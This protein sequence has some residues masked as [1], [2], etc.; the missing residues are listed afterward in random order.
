MRTYLLRFSLTTFLGAMVFAGCNK[1][2][3]D[4]AESSEIA[5]QVVVP[6]GCGNSL[7]TNLEDLGGLVSGSVQISNDA[8][9]YYIKISET[10]A[11]YDIGTVKLLYGDSLHVRQQLL[12]LIQ[13]GFQSPANPDL[14]VNYLPE[15]D[16]VLITLPI[17]SIP[18]DCFWFHARVT[19][20]KRDPG[21]GNIL[22]SY[23]LWTDGTVNASQNPCQD[24]YKYCRQECEEEDCGQLR[25]QT[26]GGWGAEPNGN[27]PGTYLH[28]NFDAAFPNDLKIGCAGGYTITMTTAQAITNLLPTGGQAAKL[29]ASAVDPAEIKNVLVG[30]LIALTLSLRF[31]I[32]DADFGPAG[33]HLGDMIIS[34]GPFA[35]KTVNQFMTIANNVIGGCSNAYSIGDINTTASLINENYVDGLVDKGYLTCPENG[36]R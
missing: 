19:V 8:T 25:T 31:D 2:L 24:M 26:P 17:A 28:A 1:S 30:H 13:C 27:N 20:V 14:V 23:D 18:M 16:E 15:Q 33:V 32:V 22:W 29:K 5:S 35:G 21:T 10:L 6:P 34:S 12:G 36:T 11:D 9:N 4:E 7:T 3:S